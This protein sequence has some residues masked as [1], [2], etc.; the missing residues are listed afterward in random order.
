MKG[1][2]LPLL[3]HSFPPMPSAAPDHPRIY[4]SGWVAV[5]NRSDRNVVFD[6]MF[7]DLPLQ[8][9][10]YFSPDP[11]SGHALPVALAAGGDGNPVGVWTTTHALTLSIAADR[12]LHV[13]HDAFG[14]TR[15]AWTEGYFRV[16]ALSA[17]GWAHAVAAQTGHSFNGLMPGGGR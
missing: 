11:A 16:I 1:A 4:D 15:T 13:R 3:S 7:G 2:I 9:T 12:P 17:E 8:V 6:H 14:G 10:I 5:S